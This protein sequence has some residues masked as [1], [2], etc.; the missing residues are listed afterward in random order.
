[1]LCPL[2]PKDPLTCMT[3]PWAGDFHLLTLGQAPVQ[4]GQPV[5]PANRQALRTAALG[6]GADRFHQHCA[7]PTIIC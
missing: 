4:V 1:M 5:S 6:A 2:P 7:T 3:C